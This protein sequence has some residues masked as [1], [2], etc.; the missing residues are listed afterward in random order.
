MALQKLLKTKCSPLEGSVGYTVPDSTVLAPLLTQLEG[1][2]ALWAQVDRSALTPVAV[3]NICTSL[4]H[5]V[6]VLL[7]HMFCPKE[8]VHCFGT[9]HQDQCDVNNMQVKKLMKQCF[10]IMAD[11]P[12]DRQLRVLCRVVGLYV[13]CTVADSSCKTQTAGMEGNS[14]FCLCR[15]FLGDVDSAEG[16]S[17]QVDAS[18]RGLMSPLL[19]SRQLLLWAHLHYARACCALN[20]GQPAVQDVVKALVACERARAL[21][22]SCWRKVNSWSATPP[23]MPHPPNIARPPLNLLLLTFPIVSQSSWLNLFEISGS[24]QLVGRSNIVAAEHVS[25]AQQVLFCIHAPC[26]LAALKSGLVPH[27]TGCVRACRQCQCRSTF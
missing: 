5:H 20:M 15:C 11:V 24:L 4:R 21:G 8:V 23:P 22:P 14:G 16:V 25:F 18:C 9:F 13:S 27:K 2:Q 6:L 12:H 19:R 26:I 10:L 3:W 1:L 17:K 7:C